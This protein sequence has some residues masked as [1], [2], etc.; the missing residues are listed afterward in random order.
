LQPEVVAA[1]EG[2]VK[3]LNLTPWMLEPRYPLP[4][5]RRSPKAKRLPKVP[6][7]MEITS[8]GR[9]AVSRYF[10]YLGSVIKFYI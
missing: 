1:E 3:A 8:C 2:D 5:L 6:P 10:E 9:G 7:S 4:K